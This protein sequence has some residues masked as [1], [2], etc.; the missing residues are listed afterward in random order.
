MRRRPAIRAG[1]LAAGLTALAA[2][3]AAQTVERVGSSDVALDRRLA[4]LLTTD[5]LIITEDRRIPVGDTIPRSVLV[6]DAT[7]I[8]EGTILGDLVAVD[9]GVFVRHR[10]T[11]DGDLV[12]VAG[13]LYRSAVARVGGTIIDLPH[14]SYRVIREHDRV[15]IEATRTPARLDLDGFAGIRVPTYDRVNGLTAEW[16]AGYRL[17][18]L[19]GATPT[20]RGHVGWRTALSDP[21][22]GGSLELRAASRTATVGYE[23]GWATHDGWVFGD[24]RNSLNYLWD[25]DDFRNYYEAERVWVGVSR[26]FGDE[27]KRFHAVL[28]LAGQIE[29]AGSLPGSEPWHIL[30]DGTR[31]NPPIDDGR[32]T[33]AT[34]AM[35]LTWHGRETNLAVGAEYEAGRDWQEGEYTFDRVTAWARFAMHGFFDHTLEV[36]TFGQMPV[37]SDTLPAQRWTFVGG[38]GRL[39]TVPLGEHRGDHVLLVQSHYRIP[40]PDA[41]ALPLLG[42]PELHLI[43]SA[44]MAWLGEDEPGMIQ[45]I[46]GRLQFFGLYVQYMVQPDDTAR[47]ALVVGTSWPFTPPFPWEP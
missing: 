16:G 5:P 32:I 12:N 1:L 17:P 20:L 14:A 18:R 27:A 41:V 7:V 9:A 2:G 31:A 30:G 26:A 25:G 22:Y 29:D 42:A 3:G 37:G 45:E 6:L 24:L 28:R 4:A 34:G 36:S 47:D 33:S 43:H 23:R 15:I 35:D 11:V 38:A 44:G 39:Q 8:H 10:A 19:L 40:T 13:G 46:G 21:T